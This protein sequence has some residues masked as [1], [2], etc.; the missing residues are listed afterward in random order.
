MSRGFSRAQQLG[1]GLEVWSCRCGDRCLNLGSQ[2]PLPPSPR[3][4]EE[5]PFPP[6]AAVPVRE[7]GGAAEGD[8][9]AV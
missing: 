3:Q 8:P 2:P 1:L 6:P 7:A 4:A 5:T 9:D